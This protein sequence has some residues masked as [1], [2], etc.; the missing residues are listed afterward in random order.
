MWRIYFTKK[1]EEEEGEE[2]EPPPP[3]IQKKDPWHEKKDK[4][5]N[6]ENCKLI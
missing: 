1:K 4:Q 6:K 2:Q 3:R 5:G